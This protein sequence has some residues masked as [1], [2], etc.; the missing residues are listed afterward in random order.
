MR[1]WAAL[2]VIVA[3]TD[4]FG[5]TFAGIYGDRIANLGATGVYAFFVISGFSVASSYNTSQGYTQYLSK[6][7]WRIVPIYYFW[8]SICLLGLPEIDSYSVLSHVLFLGHLDH[9]VTNSIIGVEW[10]ISIEIFY[11]LIIPLFLKL[12]KSPRAALISVWRV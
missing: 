3:H 4:I 7:L 2:G 11:Y 9:H 8:L 10:T 12:C 1:A 5:S 6:R